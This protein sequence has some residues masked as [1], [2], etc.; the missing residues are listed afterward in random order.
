MKIEDKIGNV[1]EVGKSI[2]LW[3][4]V[5]VVESIKNYDGIIFKPEEAKTITFTDGTKITAE[6]TEP[7]HINI[8][9]E[10]RDLQ[11]QAEQEE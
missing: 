8:H 11:E 5:K 3:S 1:Y 4:G 6:L 7:E 2:R 10:F 9:T